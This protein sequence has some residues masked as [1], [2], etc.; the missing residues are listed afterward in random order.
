MRLRD[1]GLY[2]GALRVSFSYPDDERW[3]DEIIFNETQDTLV[4]THALK[5][6]LARRPRELRAKPPTQVGIMLT[7]MLASEAHTPDL[8]DDTGREKK[9]GQLF[10]AMDTLNRALGKNSVYFGGAHGATQYAPMR[11][12]FTRIPRPEL[13]EIDRSLNRR[14]RSAKKPAA[15]PPPPDFGA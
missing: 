13:E 8:F 4:L 3:G 11:I 12:A 10:N 5:Q 1:S 2:T 15:E 6:L 9:R 7:R 14:I